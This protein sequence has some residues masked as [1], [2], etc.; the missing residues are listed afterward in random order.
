MS[1]LPE[2]SNVGHIIDI[3]KLPEYFPTMH[4]DSLFW[5]SLGRTVATFG[6]LE[7]VLGKAIFALTATQKYDSEQDLHN[8]YAD[9]L[10]IL[11]KALSDQ[12]G[13]LIGSYE[14]AMQA[15]SV[16]IVGFVDL[17][18]NLKLAARIRN[19]LCHGSWK[20]PDDKGQSVPFFVNNKTETFVTP[21]DI[22]YLATT[23]RA[24]AEL[25]C[26]VINSVTSMGWQFPGSNGPGKEISI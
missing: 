23:Q 5:E 16:E 11:E 17:I 7:E 6:Y 2:H 4:I 20:T 14:T 8:A 21:I 15:Q 9:W 22:G 3:E 25:A 12:L 26:E 13:R 19:V 24:T 1:D 10:K 18:E